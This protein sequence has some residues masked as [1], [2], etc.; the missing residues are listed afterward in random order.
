MRD[1]GLHLE[2][3]QHSVHRVV[4]SIG[5]GDSTG[6]GEQSFELGVLQGH[7]GA[8]LGLQGVGDGGGG[9]TGTVRGSDLDLEELFV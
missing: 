5:G 4:T 8:C 6:G 9:S 3:G 1:G 7:R 2:V